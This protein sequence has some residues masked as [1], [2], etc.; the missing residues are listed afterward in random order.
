M[1]QENKQTSR[2]MLKINIEPKRQI[3]TRSHQLQDTLIETPI[4]AILVKLQTSRL[5]RV[6]LTPTRIH[7]TFLSAGHPAANQSLA[8]DVGEMIG[9]IGLGLV[10]G[11]KHLLVMLD[12]FLPCIITWFYMGS[13]AEPGNAL[14]T[15]LVHLTIQRTGKFFLSKKRQPDV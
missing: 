8:S 9:C 15:F 4:R 2:K 11:R 1:D 5:H 12:V 6:G 3:N 14:S 10:F 7:W 13:R